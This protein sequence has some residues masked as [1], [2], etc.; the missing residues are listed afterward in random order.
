M[1]TSRRRHDDDIIEKRNESAGVPE[2]TTEKKTLVGT[3]HEW[4]EVVISGISENRQR[5]KES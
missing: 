3:G 5:S 2:L 4:L 1:T